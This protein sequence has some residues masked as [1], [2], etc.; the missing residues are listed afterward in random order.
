MA[1]L[2]AVCVM[3]GD[4]PVQGVIQF[5]Q[6]VRARPCRSAPLP[7][8][9]LAAVLSH[10]VGRAP[11][12]F[13]PHPHLAIP[14]PRRLRRPVAAALGRLVV[15]RGPA[16][17]RGCGAVALALSP[18]RP[19]LGDPGAAG[20]GAE[21]CAGSGDGGRGGGRMPF[22][23]LGGVQLSSVLEELGGGAAF[24]LPRSLFTTIGVGLNGAVVA[25]R[26]ELF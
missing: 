24:V 9:R 19:V 12:R 18:C 22:A 1:T 23:L 4:G 20:P 7:G 2:K 16:V 8:A 11:A 6:Q 13:F 21:E 26:P 25:E 15:G 3:K 10:R 14:P 5:Q 17:L